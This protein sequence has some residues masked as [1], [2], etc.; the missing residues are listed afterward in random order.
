ME[1][2]LLVTVHIRSLDPSD[3]ETIVE[4]SLRSWQPFFEGLPGLVGEKIARQL[5]PDWRADQSTAVRQVCADADRVWVADRNALPVGFAAVVINE[6]S[7]LGKVEMLAVDP[8]HQGLGIGLALTEAATSWISAQG[9]PL[10]EIGTGGDP[11]H[12]AARHTY[13]K[14][15]YT[16]LSIVMYYK[17]L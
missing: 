13:E 11:T 10:A 15:G 3:V 5:H 1:D 4:F 12:A 16:P 17:K 8:E 9:L 14:A 7:A 6:E 2:N